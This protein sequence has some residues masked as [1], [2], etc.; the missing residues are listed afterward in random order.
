MPDG[1]VTRA[2][3][4][5]QALGIE[6]GKIEPAASVPLPGLLAETQAPLGASQQVASPWA[7]TV[8]ALLVE[9][10]EHVQAGQP[11]LRLRSAEALRA[12]AD[13]TQARS[14]AELA[15]Q[16][17]ERDA[18]LFSEGIIH[19][20]LRVTLSAPARRRTRKRWHAGSCPPS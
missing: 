13:L 20:G 9:E 2:P 17:A 1:S 5:Q 11:V 16:H 19:A 6:L 14:E 3:S 18:P 4:Q 7:G 10:G 15:R 8:T 12:S